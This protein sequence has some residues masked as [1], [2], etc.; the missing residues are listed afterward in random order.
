MKITDLNRGVYIYQISAPTDRS[1]G[2]VS[3]GEIFLSK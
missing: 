3:V 1:V 2:L